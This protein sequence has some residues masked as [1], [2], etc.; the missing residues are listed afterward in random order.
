MDFEHSC[1]LVFKSEVQCDTA[2][3]QGLKILNFI[4]FVYSWNIAVRVMIYYDFWSITTVLHAFRNERHR[5]LNN[6]FFTK[7]SKV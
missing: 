1:Y 5:C 2:A 7:N 6:I 3:L 4:N